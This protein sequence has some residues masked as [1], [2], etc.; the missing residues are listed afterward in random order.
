MR[1]FE[2]AEG[3]MAPGLLPGDYLVTTALRR[4]RRGDVVVF[5]HP[6]RRSF[7][8]VKRIVG[9]P[10]ER[11]ELAD[12]VLRADGVAVGGAP[13]TPG[14]GAWTV[15]DDEVFVLSDARGSTLADSR[16]FGPVPAA[17]CE[18][19]RLRYWPPRRIR[20]W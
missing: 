8:L 3:S 6:H 2:V 15:A 16:T 18:R 20:L 13:P 7:W 12:G 19:V 14:D 1:R 4:P 5:P 10:G 17:D 11:M 9:L